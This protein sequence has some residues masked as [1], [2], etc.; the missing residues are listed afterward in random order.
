MTEEKPDFEVTRTPAV[1]RAVEAFRV[2]LYGC[3]PS[4]EVCRLCGNEQKPGTGLGADTSAT[5]CNECG[6]PLEKPLNP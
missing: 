3:P 5:L 4:S 2:P 1:V 6:C